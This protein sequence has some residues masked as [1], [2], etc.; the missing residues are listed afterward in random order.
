MPSWISP[1]VKHELGVII[2]WAHELLAEVLNPGDLALDLTAGNGYD[3]LKL[4]RLVGAAG[5]VIACDIQDQALRQTA[6]RLQEAGALCRRT[7]GMG[8]PLAD[9]A[10]VDLVQGCHSALAP[11]LP[12][13]PRVA[14]ANLGYLP[15]GDKELTT[16]ARTSVSAFEQIV[17]ALQPGGRLA[18]VVYPGHPEGVVEA[19]EVREFFTQLDSRAYN[20]LELQ[21]LN[22]R[23]A[24]FLLIAEKRCRAHSKPLPE[25]GS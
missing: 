14:V 21:A 11:L 25:G 13:P 5:Q 15:G 6:E 7:Q 12:R 10:G 9:Q 8:E 23:K 24:P 22:R 19:V 16:R 2:S 20:V 1:S 3:T 4:R 18:V 17:N